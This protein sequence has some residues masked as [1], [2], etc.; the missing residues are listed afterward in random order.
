MTGVYGRPDGTQFLEPLYGRPRYA[1][2]GSIERRDVGYQLIAFDMD[3]TLLDNGKRVLPSSTQAIDEA[4]A[5]SK[6]VAICSGR[7]PKMIELD[8]ASF[9]HVRYAICCNGTVLYDLAEHRVLST[10][11]FDH[12]TVVR[13]V[14]AV[15]DDDAMI[16]VFSGAD[17]YCQI[18][19][20]ARMDHYRMGIYQRLY[21]ATSTPVEDVRAKLLDPATSVQKFIF[22]FADPASR[23]PA[24]ERLAGLPVEPAESED[25]S[26]ELSPAG[27]NKGSGLAALAELLGIPC[28]ATIAVGDAEND[29]SMLRAAGLGVAMGN[30]TAEARAAADVVV[31]DNDH[32]GCAE[33]IR[34]FLLGGEGA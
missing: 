18:S 32:D 34:R 5:A 3:G 21:D 1:F 11:S 24:R 16:D 13:A 27:A 28:A 6:D 29:L 25:A 30:A 17:I 7:S 10:T 15:G 22:H 14:A 26:L 12:E 19:D 31:A 8:H 23:A 33:A 4:V 20:L 2:P 9:G